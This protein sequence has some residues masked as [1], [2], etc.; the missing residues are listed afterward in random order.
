MAYGLQCFTSSGNLTVDVSDRLSALIGTYS[1]SIGSGSTETT[2]SVSGADPSIHFAYDASGS[3][4][5]AR[6]ESGLIRVTR[7]RSA[8]TSAESGSVVMFRA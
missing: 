3:S 4:V 8:Y 1:W 6:V 7:I 5:H 2:I